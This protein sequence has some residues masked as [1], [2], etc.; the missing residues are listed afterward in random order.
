MAGDDMTAGSIEQRT[1]QRMRQCRHHLAYAVVAQ[2]RTGREDDDVAQRRQTGIAAFDQDKALARTATQEGVQVSQA[3][4][5]APAADPC[6]FR[7]APGTRA[8]QQQEGSGA[9]A[10]APVEHGG[11]GACLLQQFGI[12]E[13]RL[14]RRIGEVAQQAKPQLRIAVGQVMGFECTARG[15]DVVDA[16]ERSGEHHDGC[17]VRRNA[18]AAIHARQGRRRQRRRTHQHQQAKGQFAQTQRRQHAKRQQGRN[19][20]TVA[21]GMYQHGHREQ[22]RERGECA[23]QHASTQGEPAPRAG[24][25]QS[26]LGQQDR[27]ALPDQVMPDVARAHVAVLPEPGGTGQGQRRHGDQ[28]FVAPGAA[29][30]AGHGCPV[31]PARAAVHAAIHAGRVAAECAFERAHVLDQGVPVDAVQPA[32][33]GDAVGEG[34][35]VGLVAGP[36][37]KARGQAAQVLDQG[38]AQHR[39]HGV[40]FGQLQRRSFG[41]GGKEAHQAF[42]LDAAVAM[43][44]QFQRQLVDAWTA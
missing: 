11:R 30:Q 36:G 13:H 44:H 17:G 7:F 21:V 27:Q 5:I 9:F 10:V 8:V 23:R 3:A 34:G 31:M 40:Q 19:A 26:E 20:G 6:L 39:R 42:V 16:V 18:G 2:L 1:V 25:V 12:A 37:I 35:I 41:V 4:M 24:I 33:A 43:R 15:L 29:R 14:Q 22:Q 32:E 38:Q 28:L